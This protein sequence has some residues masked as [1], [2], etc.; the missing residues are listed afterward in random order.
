MTN[1]IYIKRGIAQ[2][3]SYQRI[4]IYW[5]YSYL[6]VGRYFSRDGDEEALHYKQA[7]AAT[8]LQSF[9]EQE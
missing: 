3:L 4:K 9:V 8:V 7:I 1:M 2:K 6:L 5:E